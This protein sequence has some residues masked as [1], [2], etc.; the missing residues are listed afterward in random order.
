[1]KGSR[2]LHC[3]HAFGKVFNR[4]ST[5]AGLSLLQ[6]NLISLQHPAFRRWNEKEMSGSGGVQ[7]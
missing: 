1:M 6:E 7:S 2:V 4:Q 5:P 3:L